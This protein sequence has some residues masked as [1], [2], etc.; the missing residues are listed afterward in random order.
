[1]AMVLR[2]QSGSREEIF[3]TDDYL[4]GASRD[5]TPHQSDFSVQY[6]LHAVNSWANQLQGFANIVR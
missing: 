1:M 5:A 2:F 4:P 6:Q 3:R